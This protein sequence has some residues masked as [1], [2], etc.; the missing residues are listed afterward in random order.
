MNEQDSG[1]PPQ[2]LQINECGFKKSLDGEQVIRFVELDKLP[3]MTVGGS[4]L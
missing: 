2:K 3:A 1:V 4:E